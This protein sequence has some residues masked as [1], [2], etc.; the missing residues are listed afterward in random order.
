MAD[1]FS[2]FELN[3]DVFKAYIS[4]LDFDVNAAEN[5]GW[6]TELFNSAKPLVDDGIDVS[7][8]PDVL[9]KQGKAPAQFTARFSA[10]EAANK[11]ALESGK[12][13]PYDTIQSYFTAEKNYAAVFADVP[14]LDDL[15]TTENIKTLITGD[16]SVQETSDRLKNALF[17]VERADSALKAEIKNMFP[18]ATDTDLARSLILGDT[19]ALKG[20]QKIGQAEILTEAKAAGISLTSS[21]EDLQKQG[22]TRETARTGATAIASAQRGLQSAAKRFGEDTT[23]LQSELEQQAFGIKESKKVKRL[24]SQARAEFEKQSGITSG[25]LS[26]KTSGLL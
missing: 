5:Q 26:R 25:S 12:A 14:G 18:S 15:G 11:R 7:L 13:K 3:I 19:S 24:A 20:A 2:Q 1:E 23:G 8:V 22:V 16:V 4:L 6:I 21:V 17:A 10:M 9:L